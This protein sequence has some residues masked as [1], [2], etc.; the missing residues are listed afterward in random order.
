MLEILIAIFIMSLCLIP[1][2]QTPI[3]AYRNEIRLLEEMERE[4]L[5]DWAFSEIKEKLLK[6]E[7]PW[8]KL[9]TLEAPAGPF[10]LPPTLIQ[11]PG[12]PPKQVERSFTLA[13]KKR[14]GEKTGLKG[15]IYRM[16]VVKVLFHPP[17]DEEKSHEYQLIVRKIH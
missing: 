13:L 14:G 9:P 5:S 2:L 12:S 4:R 8:E 1:L 7:I 10:P 16:L 3:Q 17:L 6:N 11:I 15:E